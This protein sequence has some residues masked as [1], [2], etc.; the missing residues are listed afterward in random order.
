[1]QNYSRAIRLTHCFALV[2]IAFALLTGVSGHIIW[3]KI[4][5]LQK[6]DADIINR[7][8]PARVAL[9]EAKASEGAFGVLAYQLKDAKADD[10]P[11]MRG[12]IKE[13]AR[14]FRNWLTTVRAD[15][16]EAS[17]EIAAVSQRFDRLLEFLRDFPKSGTETPEFQLEY[18]FAALRDDLEASLTHLSLEIGREAEDRIEYAQKVKSVGVRNTL[19]IFATGF[20]VF[21]IGAVAWASLAVA[22]PMLRLADAM[23]QIA[24]GHHDTEIS[25]IGRHD[26]VGEVARAILVFRD[27]GLS[28]Q[29]LEQETVATEA[30]AAATLASER[31]RVVEVFQQEVMEA[32][33]ALTSATTELQRNAT[34]MRDIAGA[35]DD[36]TKKVVAFSQDRIATTEKLFASSA[37]LTSTITKM[38]ELFTTAG[39]IAT[40]ATGDG[41]ATSIRANELVE[42]VDTIGQIADFIGGVAYQTNLLALNATIEAARCGEA[43]RGFAVVAGEVKALAHETSRAAANI[44]QRIQTVK[45]ATDQ[46]VAAIGVTVNRIGRI[47]EMSG[48]L[49]DAMDQKDRAS[50]AIA[51]C[52]GAAATEAQNLTTVLR[53]VSRSTSET[54]RVASEILVA[55]DE[56]SLYSERLL[57]RSREFC[58][59]IQVEVVPAAAATNRTWTVEPDLQSA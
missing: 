11:V 27:R 50:Q 48:Q 32:I 58:Q 28:V 25:Y 21:F 10:L 46:V 39:E 35:T 24:G 33:A 34:I 1:V 22:R 4:V 8:Y 36:R 3:T 15:C 51:R 41:K 20:I 18:R 16:P 30:R 17:Q 23:R 54:Q 12:A 31:Q 57:L 56:V 38:N 2:I 52:V 19:E 53:D 9:G 49:G 59:Q 26:E 44:A 47:A 6:T 55:T 43:G 14:R 29:R 5:D 40:L 13:E 7:Q 42:A 37:D 45:S